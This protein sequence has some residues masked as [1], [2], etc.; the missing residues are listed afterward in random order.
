M[1]K[2]DQLNMQER[3]RISN[4]LGQRFAVKDIALDLGRCRTTIYREIQRNSGPGGEYWPDR[5][6][7]LTHM[8]RTRVSRIDCCLPLEGFYFG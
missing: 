4:L 1:K 7:H 2:Y 3:E 8:R 6:A 5:A